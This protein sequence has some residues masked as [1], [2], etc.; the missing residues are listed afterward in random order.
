MPRLAGVYALLPGIRGACTLSVSYLLPNSGHLIPT[1]STPALT[2]NLTCTG[3]GRSWHLYLML[4]VPLCLSVCLSVSIYLSSSP[5]IRS[6][7][8]FVL[9][10]ALRS[11]KVK[12]RPLRRR[13]L[14]YIIT[15]WVPRV[16][17]RPDP[18]SNPGWVRR[19]VGGSDPGCYIYILRARA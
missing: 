5:P 10:Q 4:S 15:G 6:F 9:P 18:G 13:G 16:G 8:F 11:G 2:P 3:R 1:P 12:A 14:W 7:S 19:P 17:L